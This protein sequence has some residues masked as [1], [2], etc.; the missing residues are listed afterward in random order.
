MIKRTLPFLAA[1]ALTSC[2]TIDRVYVLTAVGDGCKAERGLE[3]D[4]AIQG[5]ANV[6][7]Q[8][9]AGVVDLASLLTSRVE[10][11]R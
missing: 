5:Q 2:T 1:L 6:L 11:E 9:G 7:A 4:T 10:C 3:R 8:A